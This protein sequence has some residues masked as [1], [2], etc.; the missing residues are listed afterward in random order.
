MTKNL[1]LCA[2]VLVAGTAL[3]FAQ[4][5]PELR[6]FQKFVIAGQG[7]AGG[8]VMFQAGGPGGC[9]MGDFTYQFISSEMS[10]DGKVVK[11]SPYS[12]DAA[13]ETIQTLADG[14]RITHKNTAKLYRD[15][16]GRTRREETLAVIGP[17][18]AAGDPPQVI[19][20]NDPVAGNHLRRIP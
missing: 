6:T 19:S 13:T 16:Q 1:M 18:A 20:I 15:S 4:Q 14:N 3:A 17:W 7:A 2:V 12:G 10:M 11:G 5:E 8:N 9:P